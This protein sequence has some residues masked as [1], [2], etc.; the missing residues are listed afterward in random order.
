M[1]ILHSLIRSGA[2]LKYFL[3]TC[4]CIGDVLMVYGDFISALFCSHYHYWLYYISHDKM[5]H[6]F[7]LNFCDAS[8]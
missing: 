7:T 2:E 8:G 5:Q 6:P 3:W 1:V 4:L